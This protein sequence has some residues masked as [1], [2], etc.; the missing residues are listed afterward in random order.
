MSLTKSYEFIVFNNAIVNKHCIK[1]IKIDD[2]EPRKLVLE[3]NDGTKNER[4]F[5]TVKEA[6][7][8]LKDLALYLT[9][10]RLKTK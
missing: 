7:S 9:E 10:Y 4:L 1:A 2:G 5:E 3:F 8:E 6:V